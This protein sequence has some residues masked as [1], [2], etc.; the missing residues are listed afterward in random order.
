VRHSRNLLFG[1]K[2]VK[3][4][5]LLTPLSRLPISLVDGP[6]GQALYQIHEDLKRTRMRKFE[7][8]FYLSTGYGT[9]E[10]TTNIAVGFYDTHPLIRE[11]HR[12]YRKWLYNPEEI[13]AVLRHEIGHAFCYA[14]KLYRRKDFR[15]TFNVRGHFFRTYPVTNRY[16]ERANPWSRDFVNP[17]GDHYAQKHPDE[18]FAET[19]SVWLTPHRNWRREYR[20]YPGA[21]KKLVFVDSVV[22][23]LRYAEPELENDP[24]MLDEPIAKSSMT[25][26]QFL[27]ASVVRYRRS[28]TGFVDS[29]LRKLFRRLPSQIALHRNYQMADEFIREYRPFLLNRVSSW[30]G[31]DPLVAKDLLDK[32]QHR[33][34]ELRLALY[35]MDR[36]R[37][38][39]ELACYISLRCTLYAST[40]SFFG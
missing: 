37:K 10:G 35:K 38:L 31:A 19:F 4:E 16:V 17:M 26:A 22:R 1:H 6:V 20:R 13:L 12:E 30:V 18:D 7:P 23:E 25:L 9:V 21:L 24:F 15:E 8:G 11:L 36:E 14:Y 29:D 40:G 34:K 28:A 33:A 39:V 2:T 32:C 5:L 27:K 3:L